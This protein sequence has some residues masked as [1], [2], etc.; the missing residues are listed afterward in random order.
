LGANGSLT[1]M[2]NAIV[3]SNPDNS[4]NLDIGVSSDGRFLYTLNAATGSIGMFSVQS[5]GGLVK[6]GQFDGL[7]AS[8]GLNGIAAY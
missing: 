4:T 3:S 6:F 2:G 1:Q 8:A 5:D 7:P